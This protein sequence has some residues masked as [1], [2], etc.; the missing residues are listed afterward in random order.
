MMNT[1]PEAN[2]QVSID[3]YIDDN[4]YPRAGEYIVA[5]GLWV[6]VPT[7]EEML[8]NYHVNQIYYKTYRETMAD[9]P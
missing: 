3:E 6:P 5:G 9:E 2:I 1:Q 8:Y 4:G 7:L